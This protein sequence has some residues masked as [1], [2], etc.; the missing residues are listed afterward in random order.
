MFFRRPKEPKVPRTSREVS[1]PALPRCPRCGEPRTL[2]RRARCQ[3]WP[4]GPAGGGH[5]AGVP[6]PSR[7]ANAAKI[8]LAGFPAPLSLRDTPHPAPPPALHFL[9]IGSSGRGRVAWVLGWVC[10]HLFANISLLCCSFMTER[11]KGPAV[12]MRRPPTRGPLD[13][14]TPREGWSVAGSI[15]PSASPHRR[16]GDAR[17]ASP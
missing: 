3:N 9:F 7:A 2:P 10:G 16:R 14:W 6:A 12:S 8:G 11:T 13:P 4:S 5:S 1:R 15:R 17:P